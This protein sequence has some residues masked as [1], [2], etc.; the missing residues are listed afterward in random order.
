V[1]RSIVSVL[2]NV[3]VS[4][5]FPIIGEVSVERINKDAVDE[6]GL[7]ICLQMEGC[8]KFKITTQHAQKSATE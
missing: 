3:E 5:P 1:G 4:V 8:L 6:F 7:A 2:Q